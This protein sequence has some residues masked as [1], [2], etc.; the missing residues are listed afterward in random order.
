MRRGT[1]Y[2]VT[3]DVATAFVFLLV[4]HGLL[5]GIGVARAYGL[6]DVPALSQTIPT[7]LGHV[8]LLAA[9]LFLATALAMHVWP[10]HWWVL[11]LMA[12]VVSMAAIVPSWA[13]ARTGAIVNGVVLAGVAYGAL[14]HG[15]TSLE[16]AYLSDRQ[17][18]ASGV[19]SDVAVIVSG[20]DLARVPAPVQRFL[21]R[22]GVVGQP[23]VRDMAVRMHGRIRGGPDDPWM[24]FRADQ[25]SAF[26]ARPARLFY[27]TATRAGL[28]LH[29]YHRFVEAP[30]SMRVRAVGLLPVVRLSGVEMT[31][32]ET[33]TILNDVC[34][35]A[36]AALLELPLTWQSPAEA[37]PDAATDR[38][39]VSFTH[40]DVTVSADLVIAAD[41]T[42]LDFVSDDRFATSSD[43]RSMTRR[44]WS[45]PLRDVRAFG[46]VHL[47]SAGE[48]RWHDDDR[49]WPYL[50]L[51]IDDV[52][53]NVR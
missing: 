17:A 47:P 40:G 2:A 23:R 15:P 13:D 27:M 5:H 8:W 34:V 11:G 19:A 51:T 44:R 41:G 50:E 39:R 1:G 24:P 20:D 38:V 32:S 18:V 9:C 4:V 33:V 42:L 6:T 45:T 21:R 3:R 46:P 35:M 12:V 10:R 43:G 25:Y 16:A 30:A 22:S 7:G 26:G 48:G 36:P 31:R 52:R 14:V 28:P 29:G 37:E 49:S 53:Y